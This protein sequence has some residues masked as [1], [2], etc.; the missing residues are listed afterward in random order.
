MG[1]K[2]CQCLELERARVP[3]FW[4]TI[5]LTGFLAIETWNR[6]HRGPKVWNKNVVRCIDGMDFQLTKT[7]TKIA[8]ESVLDELAFPAASLLARHL[9][10]ICLKGNHAST[11]TPV[12]LPSHGAPNVCKCLATG[13]HAQHMPH[14]AAS[15]PAEPVLQRHCVPSI[16]ESP[17]WRA[18]HSF[19]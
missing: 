9:Y 18:H 12:L 5:M 13:T 10:Y 3:T 19:L 16:C 7:N 17:V 14:L 6:I 1:K 11:E 15:E 4:E 2:A 8:T